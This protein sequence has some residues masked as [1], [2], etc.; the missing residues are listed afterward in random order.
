[1]GIIKCLKSILKIYYYNEQKQVVR[2]DLANES[3]FADEKKNEGRKR[4]HNTGPSLQSV[5]GMR[6]AVALL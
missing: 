1:M 6:R 4:K 2:V 3:C 5:P